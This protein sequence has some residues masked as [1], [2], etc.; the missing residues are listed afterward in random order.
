MKTDLRN[1]T[2]DELQTVAIECGM[3]P[4]AAKQLYQWLYRH[5]VSSFDQMTNIAVAAQQRLD[6][7]YH[8]NHL[9]VDTKLVSKD[10]TTKYLFALPDGHKIETVMIPAIRKDHRDRR[11][12]CI[13]TQVG[14]AM[15]CTFCHTGTMGLKR[16]LTQGEVLGQIVTAK[17]LQPEGEPI[18]NIVFMGMGEPLHNFDVTVNAL[19]IMADDLGLGFGK[20]RVTLSTVGHVPGIR[21]LAAVPDVD[22]QLA[23]SLHA[24]TDEVRRE[25]IP[26]A[27][28]YPL[29]EVLGACAEY[30]QIQGKRAR[31]TFEY[32]MLKDVNDTDED[33]RRLAQIVAH[34]P[35]KM[36]LI[37]W[38]SFPGARWD[39][40]SDERIEHFANL[41]RKKH[42]QVN[43]R[44]SRGDD[45]LA[46]CG[47]LAVKQSPGENTTE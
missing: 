28:K 41:L 14:C 1:L 47:Q 42:I 7:K 29:D 35:A 11:T 44:H 40:P 37:P 19:R 31:I 43:I 45:I 46:A 21:K 10:G 5:G 15:A 9:A 26:L 30:C 33:A 16:H 4:F 22:V 17:A 25:L 39:R 2:Q 8:V 18:T 20:R 32:L 12:L 23:L 24:T 38:N 34:I 13:S 27:R 6:E 3:K 36:N